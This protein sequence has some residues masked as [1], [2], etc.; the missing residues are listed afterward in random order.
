[1]KKEMK[2]EIKV[3][4]INNAEVGCRYDI[5]DFNDIRYLLRRNGISTVMITLLCG[6]KQFKVVKRVVRE[7]IGAHDENPS[8]KKCVFQKNG[9]LHYM[10]RVNGLKDWAMIILPYG[11]TIKKK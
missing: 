4:V 8:G 3:M 6:K 7:Y 2:K 5:S 9:Y 11:A 1:M 10:Y